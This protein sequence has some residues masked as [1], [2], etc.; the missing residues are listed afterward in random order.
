MPIIKKTA[1]AA[2]T[3]KLSVGTK[4]ST[5][6]TQKKVDVFAERV[7]AAGQK[8]GYVPPEPGTYNALITEIQ[9]TRDDEGKN[10]AVFIEV[11]ITDDEAPGKKA[12]IYFNFT[13]AEGI[14]KSGMPFFNQARSMLGWDEDLESWDSM[15][16]KLAEIATQQPWVV[17]EVK[18]KGKWTNIFLNSVP[19]NQDEKP[20]LPE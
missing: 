8:G 15:V 14:E 16:D 19:E 2:T 20:A 17:I 7:N 5:P 1:P 6:A 9:A 11:T 12:R 13:D 3:T 4:V 10:E 18:K